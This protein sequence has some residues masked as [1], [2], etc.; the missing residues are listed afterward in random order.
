MIYHLKSDEYISETNGCGCSYFRGPDNKCLLHDHEFYEFV[1]TVSEN[2]IHEMDGIQTKLEKYT[3]MLIRPQDTHRFVDVGQGEFS[4]L[5]LAF[6]RQTFNDIS[7]YLG[8]KEVMQ[9]LKSKKDPPMVS[10]SEKQ[11]RS[12]MNQFF[13]LMG[14]SP[15]PEPHIYSRGV[16]SNLFSK[17]FLNNFTALNEGDIPQW[18][19]TLCSEMHK[20][21]NF[22]VGTDAMLEISEKSYGHLC[23]SFKKYYNSTPTEFVNNLRLKYAKNMILHTNMTVLEIGLECGFENA[24]YFHRLFKSKFGVSPGELRKGVKTNP[25]M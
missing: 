13:Y 7:E 14:E 25:V 17:Y 6:T 21:E 2:V 9:S 20:I 22:S 16:I 4:Y 12:L 1:L 19:H 10:L 3:L 15:I 11:G 5:N 23:R 18:L 24:G 8:A